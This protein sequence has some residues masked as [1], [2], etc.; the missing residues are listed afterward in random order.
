M[1]KDEIIINLQKEIAKL[2]DVN[3]DLE[4]KV[5]DAQDTIQQLMSQKT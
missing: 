3:E 4:Y 2:K 5:E 1:S